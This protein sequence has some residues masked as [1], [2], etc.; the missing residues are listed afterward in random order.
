MAPR[1]QGLKSEVHV[2]LVLA[3]GAVARGLMLQHNMRLVISI[4]K[5]YR[6]RGVEMQDLIQVRCIRRLLQVDVLPSGLC[7]LAALHAGSWS[8]IASSE[9]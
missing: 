6:G 7:L 8:T 1:E 9:V 4:A 2:R 3:N 5:N